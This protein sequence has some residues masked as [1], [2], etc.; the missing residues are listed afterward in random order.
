MVSFKEAIEKA[1]LLEKIV[2]CKNNGIYKYVVCKNKYKI[3]KKVFHSEIAN[4]LF[5]SI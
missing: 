3:P 1:Y 4:K 5:E 2:C